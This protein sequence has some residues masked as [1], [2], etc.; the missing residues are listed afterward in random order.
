M[1]VW[2]MERSWPL[3][4]IVGANMLDPAEID[5]LHQVGSYIKLAKFI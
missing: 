5:I 3:G 2:L 1:I 4:M